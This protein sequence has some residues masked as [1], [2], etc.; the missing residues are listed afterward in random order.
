MSNTPRR[1]GRPPLSQG[2]TR[3][4]A[5]YSGPPRKRGRPPKSASLGRAASLSS[6]HV[7]WSA[8][9]PSTFIPSREQSVVSDDDLTARLV[10]PPPRPRPIAPLPAPLRNAPTD[11][12]PALVFQCAECLTIVGD[13]YAWIMAHKELSL[14]VLSRTTD[15]VAVLSEL[16]TAEEDLC[17]G[18][19]YT[20]L[21][22]ANCSRDLGR[23]FQSTPAT[24]DALR[25]VFSFHVD[26]V[27]VYQLG[28]TQASGHP[29]QVP[30]KPPTLADAADGD[31]IR[32]LLMVLGE[33]LV[34]VER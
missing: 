10:T 34:R 5:D 23:R 4:R 17:H 3:A 29:T 7:P 28:S 20:R 8:S 11:S 27:I 24:L 13:S 6:D 33:R 15:K 30:A 22:C 18:S 2:E 9:T 26:A 31:K 14:I 21:R 19:T 16:V 32:N 1:R 25:G 12:V